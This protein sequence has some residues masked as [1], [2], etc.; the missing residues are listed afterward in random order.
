[1]EEPA[2]R[3]KAAQAATIERTLHVPRSQMD[4]VGFDPNILKCKNQEL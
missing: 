2:G 4:W 1:M 3:A